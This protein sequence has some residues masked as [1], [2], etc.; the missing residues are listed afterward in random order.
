MCIVAAV[1]RNEVLFCCTYMFF[2]SMCGIL[3]LLGDLILADHGFSFEGAYG[4]CCEEFWTQEMCSYNW[5]FGDI[6][7]MT[8]VPKSKNTNLV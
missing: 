1:Y 4:L 6:L 8:E 5:L 7:Q 2:H 3:L